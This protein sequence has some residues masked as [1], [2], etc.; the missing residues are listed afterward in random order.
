[1]ENSRD[2]NV[3]N[4]PFMLTINCLAYNH[5]KYIRNT[6]E[7]FVSQKTNFRYEAIV[8][9]DASTDGTA[10]II[11]EYAEL[12]PDIIKPIFEKENLYSKCDGSLSRVMMEACRGKYV[13]YC[14]GDDYWTDPLKLQKQVDYMEAHPEV[15]YSC[16]RFHILNE[17]KGTYEDGYNAYFDKTIHVN[18]T[19]FLFDQSYPYKTD[20]ITLTL[21]QVI[22]RDAIETCYETMFK[23]Y[24]DVHLI[25]YVLSKGQGV[26]HNFFGGVY[27][28]S[29]TS[30]FGKFSN[31][32]RFKMNYS[33]YKEFYDKERSKLLKYCLTKTIVKLMTMGE[34]VRPDKWYIARLYPIAISRFLYRETKDFAKLIL[35]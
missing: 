21:T 1:M 7:S 20:W 27:R 13:A 26:C 9:D 18:E 22:R 4:K 3:E 33:V 12:Y 25:Y 8:H 31:K 29:D 17:L 11:R 16:C 23:Y 28:L 14:E 10:N 32:E 24:R 6:L 5:E 15:V 30:T 19:E 2:N 35:R 34:F